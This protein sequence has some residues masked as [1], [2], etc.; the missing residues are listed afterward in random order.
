MGTYN[1]AREG[2]HSHS[3]SPVDTEWATH[4]AEDW[5]TLTFQSV[6]QWNAANPPA[7][8]G[9]NAVVHLITDN[10]HMDIRFESCAVVFYGFSS[11]RIGSRMGPRTTDRIP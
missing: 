1:A 11:L 5:A 10:I 8:V 2:D 6:E 4:D 7:M 3:A 9:T